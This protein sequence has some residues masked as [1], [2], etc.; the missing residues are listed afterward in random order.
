MLRKL[1]PSLC[2][3]LATTA[4]LQE[5]T[6]S[7]TTAGKYPISAYLEKAYQKGFSYINK[8]KEVHELY[9]KEIGL[10]K[11]TEGKIIA[12]DPFL[13]DQDL[14]FDTTFPKGSFPVQL[15]I[16]KIDMDERVAFA[17][18]KFS[19]ELP[20]SWKPALTAKQQ[21]KDLK[22]EEIFGYGVDTG[23]GAFMDE[24]GAKELKKFLTEKDANY[25]VLTNLMDTTYQHTR[26]WLNWES[27]GANVMLFSSGYGDGFYASYIGYDKAGHIC[28]LVTDFGILG[29]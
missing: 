29:E 17:R 24:T 13:Y 12:C 9:T 2:I 27:N 16:A 3:I 5:R 8:E 1:L 6:A 26:S 19:N 28:R 15:A 18:I 21:L 4:C 20:V 25:E 11:I 14:P 7:A 22:Q 23:T 10:L